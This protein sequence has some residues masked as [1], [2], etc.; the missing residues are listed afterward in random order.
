[1][2]KLYVLL[3]IYCF[4]LFTCSGQNIDRIRG[5][6]WIS[7]DYIEQMKNRLPCECA[8]SVNYCFY[9]SI[10]S[11]N[12]NAGN[13]EEDEIIP[14]GIIN[15]II[16]TEPTPFYILFS[17]SIKYI[18]SVDYKSKYGELTLNGDTLFLIDRISSKKFIK[19]T[20]PFDF[21]G[22][23]YTSYLDNITLL[24]NALSLRL[25]PSIQTILKEDS[26]RM[27]CNAWLGDINMVYNQ[28]GKFWILEIIDGYLFIRKV[29]KHEDPLAPITTKVIKVLKWNNDSNIIIPKYEKIKIFNNM[30]KFTPPRIEW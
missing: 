25:Y 5:T 30:N 24:N 1:M 10:A 11:E 28:K 17:D 13:N 14:E 15:N 18:I 8:D 20:I 6:N 29:V 22:N 16:Q 2:N 4:V 12:I 23:K 26:L 21:F 3:A 27:D 9:I 7:V 19:S